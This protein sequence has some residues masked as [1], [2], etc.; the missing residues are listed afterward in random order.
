MKYIRTLYLALV[1]AAVTM[2]S[3][4]AFAATAE[5]LN[6]DAEQALQTPHFNQPPC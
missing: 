5:D 6:T 4:A 1:M 3:G 2:L